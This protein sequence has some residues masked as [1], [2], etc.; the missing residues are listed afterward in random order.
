MTVIEPDENDPAD[1][2]FYY[3]AVNYL[4]EGRVGM[5][6]RYLVEAQTMDIE[7]C[8][9]KDGINWDRS[10]RKAWLP[11]KPELLGVYAP[12]SL[13]YHNKRWHMFYTGCNYTHNFSECT[14]SKPISDIRLA[15]FE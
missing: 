14:G 1:L 6:G 10:E 12:H 11:R 7:W 2:Q 8:F 4:P 15:V 9:S 5:L 13:V 3:L